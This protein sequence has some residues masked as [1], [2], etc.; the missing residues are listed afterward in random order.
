MKKW[1]NIREMSLVVRDVR[2]ANR[3]YHI[4]TWRAKQLY[5]ENKLVMVQVYNNQWDYCSPAGAL[6]R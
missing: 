5:N 2:N 1:T 4:P 6:V 3:D